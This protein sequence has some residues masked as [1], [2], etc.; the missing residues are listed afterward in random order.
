MHG[1]AA[2]LRCPAGGAAG[3]D[4]AGLGCGRVGWHGR[5]NVCRVRA[6]G[7]GWRQFGGRLEAGW[8]WDAH[9]LSWANAAGKGKG[10]E[11]LVTK[12]Q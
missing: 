5:S 1:R 6:A 10:L 4:W 12:T 8:S 7:V 11:D 2:L 9:W 3:L